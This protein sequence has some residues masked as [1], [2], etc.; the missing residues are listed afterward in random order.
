MVE[1][2]IFAEFFKILQK[3]K[4]QFSLLPYKSLDDLSI[5]INEN[6]LILAKYSLW[7][8]LNNSRAKVVKVAY[9]NDYFLDYL[10]VADDFIQTKKYLRI[11]ILA[12]SNHFMLRKLDI[13]DELLD[14]ELENIFGLKINRVLPKDEYLY[15]MYKLFLKGQKFTY[16]FCN[17]LAEIYKK[18]V[19]G[20]N[21][22]LSKIF[23]DVNSSSL[24]KSLKEFDCE[25]INKIRSLFL[26]RIY[27]F[28]LLNLNFEKIVNNLKFLIKKLIFNQGI[29]IC[30]LGSDGSGK[31][32]CINEIL[33][34]Q[35]PF[36]SFIRYHFIP[37]K[38]FNKKDNVDTSRPHQ[39]P[40]YGFIKSVLKLVYL[41]SIFYFFYI[42]KVF[43][44]KKRG[45]L[46]IFDRHLYDICID[47][48][49]Y[50]LTFS[51][52]YE[53]FI[54]GLIPKNDL[55]FILN[56]DPKIIQERGKLEVTK[57]ESYN[58]FSRYKIYSSK[59]KNSFVID[60]SQSLESMK[61][62]VYKKIISYIHDNNNSIY[63]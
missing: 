2:N 7:T 1:L 38:L 19:K 11:S 24:E 50:R 33:K 43:L 10:L 63:S 47:K 58:L 17:Q 15:M 46:I 26:I 28:K 25:V 59:I 54:C 4:I 18:D 62:S 29:S 21:L 57:E 49:R 35:L 9:Q 3:R 6:D 13:D 48:K 34:L 30:V 40:P 39:L 60:N 27:I 37:V 5:V 8:L 45:S 32:T 41:F 51:K 23:S 36:R 53:N 42:P 44:P 20:C 55:C 14:Y 56:L 61:I 52:I 31:S 16:K 22:N 12:G